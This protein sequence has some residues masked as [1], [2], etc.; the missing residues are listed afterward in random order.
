MS[1]TTRKLNDGWYWGDFQ[2]LTDTIAEEA[3][4]LVLN[5]IIDSTSI[6]LFGN[7]PGD[8]DFAVLTFSDIEFL[9]KRGDKEIGDACICKI[10]FRKLIMEFLEIEDF[11]EIA[12]FED[13]LLWAISAVSDRLKSEVGT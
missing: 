13:E 11:Q 3:G 7:Q 10:E 8:E 6:N 2:K 5:E 1:A 4:N 9:E 12:A